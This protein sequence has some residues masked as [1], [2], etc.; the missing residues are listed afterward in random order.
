MSQTLR[1]YQSECVQAVL[2]AYEQGYRRV[3]YT[4]PTG[5]GKTTTFS[6]LIKQFLA[7][8]WKVL[9]LAHRSELIGQAFERIKEHNALSYYEIGMEIAE[10]SAPHGASVVVGSVMTV[11]G[12]HRLDWFHPDVI[13]VDE[14]HRAAGASYLRIIERAG[15]HVGECFYIGCTATARRTDRQSLY[16]FRPDGKRVTLLDKKG[17]KIEADPAQCVFEKHVYEYPLTSA[18][19][20][21]WL[22]PIVGHTVRTTT[23]LSEVATSL[24][25]FAEGQLARAIDNAERTNLAINAWKQI[26]AD[27]QTLVFCGSVEH[28]H[29][30]AQMWTQAGYPARAIDGTTDKAERHRTLVDFKQGRLQILCNCGVFTEGTDLPTASAIVHLRPTKSWNLYVQMCVDRQTEILT[31]Q[32]WR[33]PNTIQETDRAAGFDMQT[34]E[35]RW[36]T[37][38]GIINRPLSDADEAMYSLASPSVD[39]RVTGGHQMIYRTRV[40]RQKIP[41]SWGKI[42]AEALSDRT[43]QYQ[44]PVSGVQRSAGVPLSDDELRF[45]GWFLTDG[46]HNKKNNSITICQ[47]AHQPYH[48]AIKSCLNGCGFKYGTHRVSGSSQFTRNSDL[49]RYIVSKGKPRGRDAHLRGWSEL[50]PFLDKDFSPLL[51]DCTPAQLAA[52]LESMNQ[53]DGVKYHGKDWV[54]QTYRICIGRKVVADRLQSLCVRRGFRCNQ[55]VHYFNRNPIYYLHIKPETVRTVGGSTAQD[56]ASLQPCIYDPSEHVWCLETEMGTLITRRNGK[57]VIM[58]NTGRGTRVLPGVVNDAMTA[59]ERR[60]AIAASAKPDCLVLDLVDITRDNDLCAAPSLLDLPATLDLQGQSV[61]AA[62]R[63]LDEFEEAREQ[64]IGECPSTYQELAV[65]L[66]QVAL[67][68]DSGAASKGDWAASPDG[69]RFKRVRPGYQVALT[70]PEPGT[71]QLEVRKG[72]EQILSR[73]GKPSQSFKSYLDS[74][75]RHASEAI[76]RHAEANMPSRGTLTRLSPKQIGCLKARGHTPREI[77]A[78]PYAKARALINQYMGEWQAKKAQEAPFAMD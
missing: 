71:W 58:G 10:T 76:E 17:R 15:V 49:I 48:D 57:V 1:P 32:G 77:D 28:A 52:L 74:A 46:T 34:G 35:I 64:V 6:E 40:G 36:N 27:R 47:A 72:Q 23:D 30:A 55:S 13:I 75:A 33:T 16:A 14:C 44:I 25:D 38:Q 20:D 3:L 62:K 26:A 51:E 61:T 5:C 29:H 39:L 59:D 18:L 60:A 41:S 19:E 11:K 56:R 69:W 37:I 12:A 50:E 42:K 8:E 43:D 24:G 7:N 22:V 78:M 70:M 66:A 67:L 2:D 65:K 9:V 31:D 73:L 21:G 68:R 63:L 54:Q 53:G 45:I 4:L